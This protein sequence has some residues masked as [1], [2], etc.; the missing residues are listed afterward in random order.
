M[1]RKKVKKAVIGGIA[2]CVG[3]F[4][5]ARL[6][7]NMKKEKAAQKEEERKRIIND[8]EE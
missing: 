7:M 4:G 5:G 8:A 1:K 6:Y 2:T 3:V